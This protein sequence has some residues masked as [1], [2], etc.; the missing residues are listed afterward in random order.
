MFV[1]YVNKLYALLT[2]SSTCRRR[3]HHHYNTVSPNKP[4]PSPNP[5]ET[6]YKRLKGSMQ[7]KNFE[8]SYTE[9]MSMCVSFTYRTED[10]QYMNMNVHVWSLWRICDVCTRYEHVF[11]G[12]ARLAL[13]VAI[14]VILAIDSDW[15]RATNQYDR[16]EAGCVMSPIVARNRRRLHIYSEYC[17][18][19]SVICDARVMLHN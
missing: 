18:N 9:Y 14:P 1:R 5:Q 16:R 12:R 2:Q 4:N 15:S 8:V 6:M 7:K 13:W 10:K 19:L 11:Q 3:D 17:I